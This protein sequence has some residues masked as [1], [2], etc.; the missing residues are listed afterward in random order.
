MVAYYAELASLG[1]LALHDLR[2]TCAKLCR[3]AGGD[4]KQIQMLLGNTSVQTTEHYLGAEQN[5][6]VAVHDVLG[7]EM[8]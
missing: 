5:L 7:L 6:T 4:L 2:R 1:K 8:D 3:N